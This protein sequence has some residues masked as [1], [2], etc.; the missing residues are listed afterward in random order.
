[1]RLK[2]W[3]WQ[4]PGWGAFVWNQEELLPVTG[5][6]REKLFHLKGILSAIDEEDGE[7]FRMEEWVSEALSTSG[8]EGEMLGR[9]EVRSSLARQ[10]G[11]TGPQGPVHDLRVLG[12]SRMLVLSRSDVTQPLTKEDLW[13]WHNA[14]LDY[15][16][17]LQSIGQWRRHPE[18]MQILSGALG[19]EKLHFEAPPS[20]AVPDMM[21]AFIAW[22]RETDP[23]AGSTLHPVIRSG[24]A[25]LWL[26]SIHPFEEGN[27]RIGRAVAAKALAQ[28]LGAP[29]PFSLSRVIGRD[30]KAYYW[31]LES[32]Q[33]TNIITDWLRFFGTCILSA[34]DVAE[35]RTRWVVAKNRYIK[36]FG[37]KFNTRQHKAILRLFEAGPD[38]FAGGLT[39][40]IYMALTRSSKA[41]ATRDLSELKEMGALQVEGSGR[42]T[43]YFL[44]QL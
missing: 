31:H 37:R 28:D 29:L 35:E 22:F 24:I 17:D 8:I 39:A 15:R 40:R 42:R 14:L 33:R 10:L 32:A 27:G 11:L 38:G 44:P 41:T 25:H 13:K 12:I 23:S 20:A 9:E 34:I 18:P 43:H 7:T 4:Q 2:P 5:P 19:K 30:R 21:K 1:M 3:N 6:Y 16:S 26:E 36:R